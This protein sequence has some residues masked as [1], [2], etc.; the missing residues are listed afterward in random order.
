MIGIFCLGSILMFGC[1]GLVNFKFI[2]VLLLLE[3]LNVLILLVSYLSCLSEVYMP[4][5]VFMVVATVEVTLS[6]VSLTRI[7][8]SDC[9]YY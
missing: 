2:S 7:W 5:L 3:N 9:L 1:F 8:E 4:F 6:L